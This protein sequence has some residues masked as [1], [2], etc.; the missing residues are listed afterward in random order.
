MIY[1]ER[2][3]FSLLDY[4]FNFNICRV[5]NEKFSLQKWNGNV[6]NK[7]LFWVN[8]SLIEKWS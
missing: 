7:E 2:V 3:Q 5:V 1:S 8:Q 4:I 6:E